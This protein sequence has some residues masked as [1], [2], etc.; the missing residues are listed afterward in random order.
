[1]KK[2]PYCAEEIQDAAI[3]CRFCQHEL[4]SVP[5]AVTPAP[6]VREITCPRC[7]TRQPV[8]PDK[9]VTCG[10]ALNIRPWKPLKFVVAALIVLAVVSWLNGPSSAPAPTRRASGAKGQAALPSPT[11]PDSLELLASRGYDEHGYHKIEGQV[12]NISGQAIDNVVAVGTWYTKEGDF[13]KSDQA[14]IEF[15]PI[16]P[17]QTSPFMTMSSTNP[18]MSRYTVEF[19]H[20][21]GGTIATKDS[22]KK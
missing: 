10:Q 8:G 12:K 5:V 19:K 3:I 18:A 13:V 1:M 21:S 22:R 4:S 15:R 2:C 9:C 14:L 16:L 11:E 7:S 20:F 6:E 17:G